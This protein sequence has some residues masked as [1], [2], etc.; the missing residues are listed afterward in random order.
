MTVFALVTLNGVAQTAG[1]LAALSTSGC[2]VHGDQAPCPH[3]APPPDL[4]TTLKDIAVRIAVL[5]L[6][7]RVRLVRVLIH[8]VLQFAH[9]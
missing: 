8:L 6:I 7:L 5:F 1:T 4:E 2:T 9:L 3:T